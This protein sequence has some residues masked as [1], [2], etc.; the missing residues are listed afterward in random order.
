MRTSPTP[1]GSRRLP[2]A[3]APADGN[4]TTVWSVLL[5]TA[6]RDTGPDGAHAAFTPAIQQLHAMS[7]VNAEVNNGGFNQL[8]FNGVGHWLP[9]AIE[10]F[11][12]A[13]LAAH[14]AILL[15]IAEPA[16]A[17]AGLR[18]R[19]RAQQSLEAFSA[20]YDETRLGAFDDRWYELGDIY[21][22]LDRFVA[23][24]ADEIWDR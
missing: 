11:A 7:L 4:S 15:E 16:A 21:E 18:A 6:G 9:R 13:D 23:D 24:H 12:A 22:Q 19:A 1:D 14:R 8:F 20:T 3:E 10:G 5:R 2:A 17:E